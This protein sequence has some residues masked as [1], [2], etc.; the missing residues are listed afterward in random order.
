MTD[1]GFIPFSRGAKIYLDK[2]N[3]CFD[4]GDNLHALYYLRK[5]YNMDKTDAETAICLSQVLNYMNLFDESTRVL[6]LSANPNLRS[7]AHLGLANNFMSMDF[8]SAARTHYDLFT[9]ESLYAG[10]P[11]LSE[12]EEMLELLYDYDELAVALDLPNA[13]DVELLEE[14]QYL[15]YLHFNGQ[16]EKAL[17][18]LL[19]KE[20]KSPKSRLLQ[21]EIA[22][23]QI[24]QKQYTEAEQRLFGMLGTCKDDPAVLCLIALSQ[25]SRGKADE[26]KETMGRLKLDHSIPENC[27][28][29]VSTLFLELGMT[30]QATLTLLLAMNRTPYDR[31]AMHQ[32]AY[33]MCSTGSFDDAARV[34]G[35]LLLM[36]E[37]D[38]VAQYYLEA[39]KK[40]D[41]SLCGRMQLNYEVPYSEMMNRLKYLRE[42]LTKPDE[43]AV[44]LWQ[45]DA[46]FSQYALWSLHSAISPLREQIIRILGL[47]ARDEDVYILRDLLLRTYVPDAIKHK[48]LAILGKLR[49]DFAYS[50]Y[51]EGS[52]IV[53]EHKSPEFP[54][55]M[56]KSFDNIIYNL[57]NTLIAMDVSKSVTE[58]AVEIC[59]FYVLSL[60]GKYPRLTGDQETAMAAAFAL[61]SLSAFKL[62]HTIDEI[63]QRFDV[64]GRRVNNALNRILDKLSIPLADDLED[65]Q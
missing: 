63:C 19:A 5:A 38:S 21:L 37:N 60:E 10:S 31:L 13:K 61:L 6:L 4:R 52:W 56:P 20:A 48:A 30:K 33:C 44:K 9:A 17:K 55:N 23:T 26:A 8:F 18:R 15:R 25:Y 42:G 14:L 35:D 43:E 11:E 46:K 22:R 64:S 62:D 2:G 50:A 16:S 36:D 3:D 12:D 7:E 41:A 40:Q 24:Q 57:L 27:L 49:P 65:E 51:L 39:V 53:V 32:L 28:L 34:Y 47:S 1:N 45:E 54:K 59:K 29:G 58:T